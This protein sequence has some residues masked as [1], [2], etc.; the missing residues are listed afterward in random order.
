MGAEYQIDPGNMVYA[1]VATGYKPGSF[2]DVD[3]TKP[4]S[5][6]TPY[7]AESL[8]AYEAGFKGR[9]LPNLQFNT[10]VYYYDYSKFQLTGSTFLT[11]NLTGGSPLV[12]IYTTIVP[13]KM[14]GWENEL[15]WRPT[16]RDTLNLGLTRQ[17]GH[18]SGD[19]YVGFIY[20]NQQNFK[21][22]ELD[23]LARTTIRGSYE[24]RFD[25]AGGGNITAHV[26]TTYNSGYKVS[27]YAGDG[28]PFTGVYTVLPAQFT[29][30]SFTRS[31]LM[32]SYTTASG[33]FSI[34]AFVH[35]IENKMQ[36]LGAPQNINPGPIDNPTSGTA[37]RTTV[38]VSD[39][40]LFGVRLTV[41]Y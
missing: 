28:N 16:P 41:R 9:I 5:G 30:K 13:V 39:P 17:G 40:R 3:P 25:L 14:S 23:L 20:S 19:A 2:N 32:I 4:G 37:D 34:D 33:K 38:R 24:H 15:I 29:Q 7:G 26:N 12:L 36:L 31:D 8:T 35:N 21:G 6:S 27:N 1:S 22:K 10:S 11:P 18:F